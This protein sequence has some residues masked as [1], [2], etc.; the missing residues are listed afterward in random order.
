[1]AG[2]FTHLFV[3]SASKPT[4]KLTRQPTDGLNNNLKNNL[5]NKMNLA[6]F[7]LGVSCVQEYQKMESVEALGRS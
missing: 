3:N 5:T 7:L 6:A 4:S 2:M 1:M